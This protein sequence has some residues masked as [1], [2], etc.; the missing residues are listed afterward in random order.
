MCVIGVV[1]LRNKPKRKAQHIADK[2]KQ[3]QRHAQGEKRSAF[4]LI[5]R[6][7]DDTLHELHSPFH[8]VLELTWILHR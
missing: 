6:A 2:D 4:F 8:K 3:D 1:I 7:G 5:H